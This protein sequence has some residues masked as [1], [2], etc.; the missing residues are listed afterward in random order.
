M[1]AAAGDP[2]VHDFHGGNL[3]DAV[4]E[5]RVEPGGFGVED[6]VAHAELGEN[7]GLG[8]LHEHAARAPILAQSRT[9]N[10]TM[11]AKAGL[12]RDRYFL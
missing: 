6:E 3:D 5:R 4:T 9:R 8:R 7:G 11:C 1:H 2:A 12:A 10:Q